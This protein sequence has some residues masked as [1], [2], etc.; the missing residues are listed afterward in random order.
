MQGS[1]NDKT[2]MNKAYSI[3]QELL[4][5]RLQKENPEAHSELGD[6]NS[7]DVVIVKGKYDHIEN[8]LSLARTP[9]TLVHPAQ[10][11]RLDL[12]PDQVVFIN[13]P[14]HLSPVALKKIED[15]VRAGGFLF[16]TDWALRY[17]L[18]PA[19]PG[20]LRYNERRT[21]DE[22]V[23]VELLDC[24]DPFLQSLLGPV[25]D[26]QW[27]LEGSS[28]PIEILENSKVTVLVKSREI[29]VKYGV[30]A[31]EKE[32]NPARKEPYMA[33]MVPLTA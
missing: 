28:Y 29:E 23:R 20:Y 31:A 2:M 11:D 25:D 21:A 17:V 30:R 14:G 7:S 33:R 13:C 1:G 9:F 22:V 27:W 18:E 32:P 16:T 24:E 10:L 19:F 5:D 15:F 4:R 3:A 26:P 6:I 12:R 8:V